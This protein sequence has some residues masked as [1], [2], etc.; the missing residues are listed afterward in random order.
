M[1]NHYLRRYS[2]RGFSL[3]EALVTLLILAFGMLGLAGFQAKSQSLTTESYQ[4]AQ[5]I[6]L[7][8]DLANRLSANRTNA[9]SYI[10]NVVTPLGTG[11]T[12]PTD[13][14]TGTPPPS[15]AAIDLCEW[16]NALKGASEKY[17]A[18]RRVGGLVHALGCVDL[19]AGSQP[20]VYRVTVAWQGLTAFA[21]P[22]VPCG[23]A[24]DFGGDGYRRVFVGLV[25][26]A[27][28]AK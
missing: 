9:A 16:S 1:K 24:S 14:S 28:L 22:A 23:N 13:C 8:Q 17:S 3:I 19:I 20:P 10:T 4:R 18:T 11:D 25:P 26:I 15:G 27:D 21:E 2:Q 12:Q 6:L 5:A 7:V